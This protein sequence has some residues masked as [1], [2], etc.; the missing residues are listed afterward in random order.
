VGYQLQSLLD[1]SPVIRGE[2]EVRECNVPLAFGLERQKIIKISDFTIIMKSIKELKNPDIVTIN[3]EKFQVI[4]NTSVWHH[5]DKN[6][7]EM[8]VR[9]VKVGEKSMTPTHRLHYIYE[10]PDEVKLW[11]LFT[12]NKDSKEM[13]EI[14]LDSHNF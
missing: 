14:N 9:L 3:G 4:E 8:G 6:E 10:K 11:K 12:Y 13:K 5:T 1:L 2:D 7:L